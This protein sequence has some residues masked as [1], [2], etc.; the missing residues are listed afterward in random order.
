MAQVVGGGE[1]HLPAASVQVDAGDEVQ[2][3]VD[4]VEPPAGQVCND[5]GSQ[6]PGYSFGIPVLRS[7]V[8]AIIA[9][10]PKGKSIL[11]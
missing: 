9:A 2:L 6:N 4:P 3:R 11:E 10:T 8:N 1:Q 5:S 7:P